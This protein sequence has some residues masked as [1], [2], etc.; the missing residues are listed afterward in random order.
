M[1]YDDQI[2]PAVRSDISRRY[3]LHTLGSY[4][5]IFPDLEIPAQPAGPSSELTIAH[6]T[7]VVVTTMRWLVDGGP[8]YKWYESDSGWIWLGRDILWRSGIPKLINDQALLARGGGYVELWAHPGS[9][10]LRAVT[11]AD[12]YNPTLG[13]AGTDFGKGNEFIVEAERRLLAQYPEITDRLHDSERV[14]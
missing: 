7:H 5:T 6:A 8:L 11:S 14:R 2:Y 4:T 12:V 13:R 1:R 9:L 10:S 3:S